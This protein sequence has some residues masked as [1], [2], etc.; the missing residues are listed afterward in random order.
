MLIDTAAIAQRAPDR[1]AIDNAVAAFIAAG[2][3]ITEVASGA[4]ATTQIDENAGRRAR[5]NAASRRSPAR[6]PA[7][8]EIRA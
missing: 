5:G 8:K 6:K 4:A 3:K 1:A 2:G 7:R